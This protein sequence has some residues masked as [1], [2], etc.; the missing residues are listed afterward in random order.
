[1]PPQG[2]N[3]EFSRWLEQWMVR[4]QKGTF[5]E[6]EVPAKETSGQDEQPHDRE[7]QE[8]VLKH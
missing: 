6:H 4:I 5:H 1:M 7:Q 2:T 3:K 8:P